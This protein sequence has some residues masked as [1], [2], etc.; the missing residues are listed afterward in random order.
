[1]AILDSD[2]AVMTLF[3]TGYSGD[4]PNSRTA[5][6]TV[7]PFTCLSTWVCSWGHV[8]LSLRKRIV[9]SHN[10]RKTWGLSDPPGGENIPVSGGCPPVIGLRNPIVPTHRM[11]SVVESDPDRRCL[12]P[13]TAKR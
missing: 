2:L 12:L 9:R 8:F 3:P 13:V 6:T 4:F 11:Q 10:D 7:Y 1:M 5:G